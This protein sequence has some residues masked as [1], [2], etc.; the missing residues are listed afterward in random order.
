MKTIYRKESPYQDIEV[1][2]TVNGEV[3]IEIYRGG[4][5]ANVELSVE[6]VREMALAILKAT[7]IPSVPDADIVERTNAQLKS[8]SKWLYYVN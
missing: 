6:D 5:S 8:E 4:E 7:D 2:L 1:E 3:R